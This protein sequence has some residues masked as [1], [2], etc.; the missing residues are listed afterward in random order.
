VAIDSPIPAFEPIQE[1][2]I[3]SECAVAVLGVLEACLEEGKQLA[4][5][6]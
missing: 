5:S 4:N 3:V 2:F 6:Q 1:T